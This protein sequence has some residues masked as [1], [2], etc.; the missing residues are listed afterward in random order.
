MYMDFNQ[1]SVFVSFMYLQW[2]TIYI[3]HHCHW[4]IAVV[5][6]H[7]SY[8]S[9]LKSYSVHPICYNVSLE[10][11]IWFCMHFTLNAHQFAQGDRAAPNLNWKHTVCTQLHEH[12]ELI[13]SQE[14]M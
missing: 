14:T 9:G 7:Y 12:L 1:L 5:W 6:T 4:L 2:I 10:D 13:C 8:R 11:S 3:V